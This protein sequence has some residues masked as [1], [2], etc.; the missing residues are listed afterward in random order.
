MR[1]GRRLLGLAPAAF[2]SACATPGAAVET[3]A[4]PPAAITF[5]RYEIDTGPA[6]RQT[7]LTGHLLGGELADLIVVNLDDHDDRRLHV[8]AF[9]DGAW[10][11]AIDASLRPGVSFV[12][13]ARIDGR[14]RLITAER[15]VLRWF[16]PDTTT[17]RA[18]V[19]VPADDA[20]AP[21]DEVHH[22]DVARDL[23][24]D[25]RDD[26]VVPDADST[27]VFV[28]TSGGEFAEPVR[29]GSPRVHEI[30][31]DRDGRTDLASWSDGRF[32]VRLQDERGQF[33]HAAATFTP[34]VR[35]DS[36]DPDWLA[37]PREARD[38]KKDH[39]LEGS[40]D[41]SVLYSLADQDGDG[42]AD[43]A[44]F[45]L[46]GG[47][48]WNLE[49]A[50]EVHFGTAT[51]G[52]TAFE[53]A[54]GTAVR[55]DGIPFWMARHD[56]DHDGRAETLMF[57]KLETGVFEAIGGLLN[58][59]M[60]MDVEFSRM[61]GGHFP[62][63]PTT[64][65]AIKTYFPE[66]RPGPKAARFEPVLVGDVNGDRRADLLIGKSEELRVYLGVRGPDPFARRP[67]TVAVT[68][69]RSDRHPWLADLNRDGRQDV[70]MHHA[71]SDTGSRRVT[72]LVA[73][74]PIPVATAR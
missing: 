50:Y 58:R 62:R 3:G 60:T 55:S 42:V 52:G 39:G 11:R 6:T 22:R 13:V 19:T 2:L 26:L 51:P 31:Y 12:D 29:I 65:R 14:D 45:S 73:G 7:V 61:E 57:T 68:M 16:D 69:P 70:V 25:G 24:G 71:A 59:S 15:G 40:I 72:L 9:R 54:T 32:E 23:N 10:S 8:Y 35:F 74:S 18:L 38:R 47:S 36:D 34:E 4:A 5:E 20:D 1:W 48:L 46:G 33:L 64:T 30:D 43:L 49:F 41:G 63:R 27:R 56:L 66:R 28:Q 44:L 67:Q 17:E 37:A 53:S 21:A